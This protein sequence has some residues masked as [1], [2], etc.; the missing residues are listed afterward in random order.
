MVNGIVFDLDGVIVNSHPAHKRAWRH[1][2]NGLGKKTSEADLDF[3]LEGR[4]REDILRHFLGDL[5]DEEL[6]RFGRQK[7][8]FFQKVAE[9]VPAVPGVLQ[10]LK[11]LAVAGLPCAIATSASRRRTQ[12]TLERLSLTK[13]FRAVVTG[14]DVTQGKPDPAIYR[15]AAQKLNLSPEYLLAIEDAPAGVK[16]ATSA[17]MLCIGVGSPL[18]AGDLRKAGA[19][20]VI[21]DFANVSL[22]SLA[23]SILPRAAQIVQV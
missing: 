21:P 7:D 2:L 11:E 19:G 22:Q 6:A 15:L 1:F 8:E 14:D 13:H 17:G 3:I 16:A 10:F 9:E 23:E 12:L 5:S 4:K 18:K 20:H